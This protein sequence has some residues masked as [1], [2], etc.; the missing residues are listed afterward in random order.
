MTAEELIT[1]KIKHYKECYR[2]DDMLSFET[3]IAILR[4]LLVEVR[5]S[6]EKAN[7]NV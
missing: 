2:Q 6:K 3:L 4:G 1:E 7:N 5:S